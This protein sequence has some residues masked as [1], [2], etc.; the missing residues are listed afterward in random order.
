GLSPWHFA[1]TF[2]ALV[3][4][5]PHRYLTAVRLHRAATLLADGASVTE[6]CYRVGFGSLSHFVNTFRRRLGVAPSLAKRGAGRRVLRAALA[7][8]I[9]PRSAG[10]QE[11]ASA[12]GGR[13]LR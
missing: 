10:P 9:W 2:R 7:S 13:S 8:P 1:R 11:I 6:T 3:G 5:P 4:S 12:P